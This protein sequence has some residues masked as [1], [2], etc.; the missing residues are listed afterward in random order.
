LSN[1]LFEVLLED[2]ISCLLLGM[3]FLEVCNKSVVHLLIS[4]FHSSNRGIV[5]DGEILLLSWSGFHEVT[6][7]SSLGRACLELKF[8]AFSHTS[9]QPSV[10]AI[11]ELSLITFFS[12]SWG[13]SID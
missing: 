4:S 3:S 5:L 2:S 12:V 10:E 11:S 1:G 9:E 13:E 8:L 6:L 7:A